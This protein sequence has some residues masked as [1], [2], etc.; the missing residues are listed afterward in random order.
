MYLKRGSEFTPCVFKFPELHDKKY[1]KIIKWN[2]NKY[3]NTSNAFIFNNEVGC[4][5]YFDRT[6]NRSYYNYIEFYGGFARN[7][8]DSTEL[9][10]LIV[11]HNTKNKEYVIVNE[12]WSIHNPTY[13]SKIK[14]SMNILNISSRSKLILCSSEEMNREFKKIISP[15]M[16]DYSTEEQLKLSNLFINSEKSKLI[17]L[18]NA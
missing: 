2:T 15:T 1:C 11:T 14:K 5:Y 3:V 4:K 9:I 10:A 13:F 16:N 7:Y 12:K 18:N 6:L 17:P 8:S